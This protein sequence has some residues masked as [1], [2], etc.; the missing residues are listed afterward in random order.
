M[1][2]HTG[3]SGLALWVALVAVGSLLALVTRGKGPLPGD[4]ALAGF[5]QGLMRPD[6]VAGALL[7]NAD[8]AV[9]LLLAAG[10]GATLLRRQWLDAM[11]VL[12]ASLT[13]V[14]IGVALKLLVARPRPPA[15]LVRVY[16][17]SQ[18]FSFPSTT[19]F[20]SVVLLG[21]I[22]YLIRRAQPPRPVFD[23]VLGTSLL[24][25]VVI[26]LS[27]MYVGEHWASDVLG[28]WLFGA[29]WLLVLVAVH[30][31][32]LSRGEGLQEKGG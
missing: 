28:G 11:F 18:T 32:W 24:L 22:V 13:A 12:L 27:R 4:L 1:N 20:L 19:A 31:R 16:E 14:F 30:R 10:L 26:G 2:V 15:E 17:P 7:S 9:W 6:S 29:A 25:I 8:S 21:V 3:R 23:V 5:F